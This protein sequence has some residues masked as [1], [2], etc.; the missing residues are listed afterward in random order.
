MREERERAFQP[1]WSGKQE[2]V[3]DTL[4]TYQDR[5]STV[6]LLKKPFHP[7]FLARVLAHT[8]HAIE[9]T[10]VNTWS[11]QSTQPQAEICCNGQ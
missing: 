11:T 5:Y 9:S 4:R 2:T 1:A 6:L 7:P 8:R 10:R 3:I